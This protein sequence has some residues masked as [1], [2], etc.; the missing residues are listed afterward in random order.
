MPVDLQELKACIHPSSFEGELQFLTVI[1]VHLQMGVAGK[2]YITDKHTCFEAEDNKFA[3]PH[4]DIK[5]VSKSPSK[6]A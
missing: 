3:I 2:L 5:K 6:Q 1:A 4:S